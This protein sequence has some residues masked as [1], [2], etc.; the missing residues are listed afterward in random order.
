MINAMQSPLSQFSDQAPT[1][2]E[3]IASG[4]E[5]MAPWQARCI[6]AYVALNVHS[7]IRVMDLVRVVRF[8]PNRFDRVFKKTFDCTPHQ[9]VMRIRIARAR[10]LLLETDDSLS[11]IAAACGFGTQSHLSNLFR[12]MMGQ[13][14]G[15][16]RRAESMR[17]LPLQPSDYRRASSH[18][19]TKES[20]EHG[21]MRQRAT[22]APDVEML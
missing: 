4:R 20:D 18:V 1:D 10:K 17:A 11:K 3:M 14:P 21:E 16:W 19:F 22:T 13:P 8:A 9:Y 15:K 12:K 5:V 6:Q 2:S 7:T